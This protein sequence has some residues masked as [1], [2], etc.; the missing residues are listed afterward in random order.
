MNVQ[1]TEFGA[2]KMQSRGDVKGEPLD[3]AAT[4]ILNTGYADQGAR[5]VMFSARNVTE[6]TDSPVTIAVT[7][8]GTDNGDI[9][10]TRVQQDKASEVDL[11]VDV[12]DLP[13]GV[14]ITLAMHIGVTERGA[15]SLE[16]LVLAFDRGY[17]PVKDAYG[18]DASL[19][20]FTLLGV[21]KE[22]SSTFGDGGG[23]GLVHGKKL[24][25]LE[26]VATVA[27]VAALGLALAWRR[28]K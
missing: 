4:I 9:V 21:N 25:G 8:F 11:W 23:D 3:I 14:P 20:S 15:Y 12:L 24:P 19:F 2:I 28:R 10:T 7:R 16:V 1:C 6:D 5:W 26:F 27:S 13:V 22:T 18:N 17:A